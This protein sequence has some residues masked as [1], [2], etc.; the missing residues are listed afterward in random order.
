[1]LES[2]EIGHRV[3]KEVYARGAP[4]PES[5]AAC[6]PELSRIRCGPVLVV[7][8]GVDGA[9]REKRRTR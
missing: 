2:A 4:P 3:A 6:A 8:S 7:V 9:G 5:P 1:M